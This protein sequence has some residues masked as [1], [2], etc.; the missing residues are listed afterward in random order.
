MTYARCSSLRFLAAGTRRLSKA[1]SPRCPGGRAENRPSPPEKSFAEAGAGP[2][3]RGGA[4][5]AR[6]R[7][8]MTRAFLRCRVGPQLARHQPAPSLAAASPG[9]RPRQEAALECP[10]QA[11][12]FAHT[13]VQGGV[14][15]VQPGERRGGRLGARLPPAG[16]PAPR[17]AD[18]L[19]AATLRPAHSTRFCVS[20][21]P[22]AM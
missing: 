11:L 1:T 21:D 4:V 2:R 7:A 12:E 17:G 22:A 14:L 18:A 6:A 19:R 10:D 9:R 3:P 13:L 20:P 5:G 16:D 15:G 8:C